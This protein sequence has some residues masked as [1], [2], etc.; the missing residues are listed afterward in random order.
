MV[1]N[2]PHEFIYYGSGS[3]SLT[4]NGAKKRKK[5]GGIYRGKIKR[6]VSTVKGK[7]DSHHLGSRGVPWVLRWRSSAVSDG[8]TPTASQRVLLYPSKAICCCQFAPLI[9][10]PSLFHQSPWYTWFSKVWSL[11]CTWWVSSP[12]SLWQFLFGQWFPSW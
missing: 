12:W 9:L 10:Y 2:W 1:I 11:G 5:E 6:Y 7:S 3:N 8:C 4:K